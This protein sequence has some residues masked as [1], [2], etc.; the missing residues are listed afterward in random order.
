MDKKVIE[1]VLNRI[2]E[3]DDKTLLYEE[4]IHHRIEQEKE[5]F[6]HYLKEQENKLLLLNEQEG[7]RIF[8]EVMS[9]AEE[10]A[11]HLKLQYD[12]RVTK[13]EK[14]FESNKDKVKN[15]ILKQIFQQDGE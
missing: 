9:K 3:I 1:K 15:E 14:S 7:K 8:D 4:D 12:E 13:I 6:K 10:D 2:I 11:T 5:F